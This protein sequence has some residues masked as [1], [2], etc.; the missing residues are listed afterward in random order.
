MGKRGKAA[1]TKAETETYSMRIPSELR[2][3]LRQIALRNFRPLSQEVI[4]AL[5]KHVADE[6]E[7]APL[8]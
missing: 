7:K 8:E 2:E 3:K 4:L 1:E 6:E 5:S